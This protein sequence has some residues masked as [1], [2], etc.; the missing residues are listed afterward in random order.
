MFA[1]FKERN[2]NFTLQIKLTI[3]LNVKLKQ[4]LPIKNN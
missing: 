4:L 1:T 2:E 3:N